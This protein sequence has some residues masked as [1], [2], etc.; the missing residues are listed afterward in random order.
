LF[1]VGIN[2]KAQRCGIHIGKRVAAGS[3]AVTGW[4]GEKTKASAQNREQ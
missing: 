1:F 2:P 3:T 4:N